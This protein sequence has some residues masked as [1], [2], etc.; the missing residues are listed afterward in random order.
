MVEIAKVGFTL[1]PGKNLV[2]DTFFTINSTLYNTD[3]LIGDRLDILNQH[4]IEETFVHIPALN[5]S[6]ILGPLLS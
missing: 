3:I 5:P 2:S 4:P 1:S 6:F